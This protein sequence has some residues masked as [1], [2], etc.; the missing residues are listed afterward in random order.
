MT[1]KKILLLFTTFLTI[2][3]F[4]SSYEM[5]QEDYKIL[6]E[7]Y[8][9]AHDEKDI[10]AVSFLFCL[11]RVPKDLFSRILKHL[12]KGFERKLKSVTVT[13]INSDWPMEYEIVGVKYRPNLE[14]EAELIIEFVKGSGIKETKL[15]IGTKDGKKYLTTSAPV[16]KGN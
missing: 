5:K 2:L 1:S 7:G 3:Y 6:I 12:E 10:E 4:A 14:P 16:E 9:K 15:L 13:E 11:D 8:K